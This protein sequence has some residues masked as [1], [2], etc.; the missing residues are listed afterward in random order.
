MR[1][2]MVTSILENFFN[3]PQNLRN[4]IAV[5]TIGIT[6]L[7][8][9]PANKEP[10][11]GRSQNWLSTGLQN[12]GPSLHNHDPKHLLDKLKVLKKMQYY[13]QIEGTKKQE[14]HHPWLKSGTKSNCNIIWIK[15][16]HLK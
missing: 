1:M 6:K 10:Q 7:Q 4:Q 2:V 16:I 12:R 15:E 9:Y 8:K 11:S 14:L 13:N 3:G 5:V